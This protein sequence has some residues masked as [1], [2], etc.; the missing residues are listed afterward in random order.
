MDLTQFLKLKDALVGIS[1][2]V[3]IKVEDDK[4]TI[5]GSIARKTNESP[6]DLTANPRIS[7][8][9][10]NTIYEA[11]GKSVYQRPRTIAEHLE[12]ESDNSGVDKLKKFLERLKEAEENAKAIPSESPRKSIIDEVRR[13]V[14]ESIEGEKSKKSEEAQE[15]LEKWKENS[16]KLA[17]AEEKI[18]KIA[19][20]LKP[21]LYFVKL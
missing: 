12:E 18:Q 19:R 17:E 6:S 3:N 16:K 14:Q 13:K 21:G 20:N 4:F 5:T 2:S 11:Q 8:T 10:R 15:S 9:A 1:E 7:T